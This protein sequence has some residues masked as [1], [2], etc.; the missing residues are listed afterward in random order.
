MSFVFTYISNFAWLQSYM[1]TILY[2]DFSTHHNQVIIFV[3]II[4]N[5]WQREV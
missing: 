2:P 1:H 5:I 4:I 3:I